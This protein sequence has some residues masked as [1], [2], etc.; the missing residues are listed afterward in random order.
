M[1]GRKATS[2][3]YRVYRSRDADREATRHD[4]KE[5]QEEKGRETAYT[6]KKDMKWREE[7]GGRCSVRV[8][9]IFEI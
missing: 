2:Q 9:S 3:N 5:T 7:A 1:R 8:K 6:E 4:D